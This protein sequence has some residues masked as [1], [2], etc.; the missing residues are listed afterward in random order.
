[1]SD[2]TTAAANAQNFDPSLEVVLA[3]HRMTSKA[4]G[5]LTIRT[6][7]QNEQSSPVIFERRKAIVFC[8]NVE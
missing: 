5:L 7:T 2:S 8:R 6:P 3:V 4:T 1:M